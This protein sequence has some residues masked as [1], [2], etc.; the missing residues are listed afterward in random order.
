M[1]QLGS[2][3]RVLARL[4]DLLILIYGVTLLFVL[5]T[6]GLAIGPISAYR[7][8]K[9][10]LVLL[11]LVP[12][13]LAL[14]EGSWFGRGVGIA[15][16]H[17]SSTFAA[18]GAR[19]GAMKGLGDVVFALLVTRLPAFAVAFVA[20]M[21]I[22]PK[23]LGSDRLPFLHGKL[24]DI[25]VAWDSGWYFDIARHGYDF[26]PERESN[27]AFFPLYP[28]LMRAI[29]W[30][31]GGSDRAIWVA[32]IVVSVMAFAAALLV[33]HRVTERLLGS[34]EVARRTVLLISVFPFS[35]FFTV[36]YTEALFLLLTLLAVA[37]AYD[38]RWWRAG[39]WGGLAALT[40]PNGI[41]ILVP[42][43]GL[44]LASPGDLHARVRRLLP[45][46]L[47]PAALAAFGAFLY[48]LSGDPLAWLHAQN[49]WGN[50]LGHRPWNQLLRLL[51]ALE[52]YG[53]YDYFFTSS[54]AS[55]D[56]IHGLVGLVFLMLT[57][58]VFARL[59]GP[60]GAYVLISLL[61]PLSS[62]SLEGIG[63]YAAVL[64]PAF[65]YLGSIKS[66]RAYEA[67]LIVSA[68]FF[69]LFLSLFVLHH[70]IY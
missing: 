66:S 27:V 56:L 23:G 52:Q 54:R 47:I 11:L 37:A 34:R 31:F 25:F 17:L 30:P 10:L 50:S 20:N 21:L 39:A 40:R 38:S 4:L 57:P 65:M 67:L 69:A 2:W 53:L 35:F 63:R 44:A 24:A 16:R 49:A 1:I 43:A 26:N 13:R 58:F 22:P 55:F 5:V 15:R 29:A 3:R 9:P 64:F 61:V 32:G 33:L 12:A 19:G 7:M 70:Q 14:S 6:G 45:L 42:L 48:H 60:L 51:S 68:L 41:L 62:Q 59:G 8:A 28:L 18:L 46:G 36:V